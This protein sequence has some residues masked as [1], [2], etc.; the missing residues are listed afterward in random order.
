[1]KMWKTIFGFLFV[2][3]SFSNVASKYFLVE[4][5]AA[6]PEAETPLDYA[7]NTHQESGV[8]LR[9]A[10]PKSKRP[11]K[12]NRAEIDDENRMI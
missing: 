7:V 4:V 10:A 3:L 6:G 9:S 12:G 8:A 2:F 1:M 5:G 11:R